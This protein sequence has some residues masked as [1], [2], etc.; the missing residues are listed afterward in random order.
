MMTKRLFPKNT[1]QDCLMKY[2]PKPIKNGAKDKYFY[3]KRSQI[4]M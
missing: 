2:T 4:L 1:W 3:N